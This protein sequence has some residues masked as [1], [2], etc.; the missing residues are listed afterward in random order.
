MQNRIQSQQLRR[1]GLLV[2]GIFALIGLW[3]VVLRSEEPRAWALVLGGLL[4][5]PALVWPRGLGPVYRGW[6]TIG[7]ALG[8]VNTR[9]LLGLVFYGLITPM[10][11][12]RRFL[13]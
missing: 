6:M 11:L 3:P 5:L 8:W 12:V 1:F 4:I 2:G 10:G 9:L 7:H 13:L